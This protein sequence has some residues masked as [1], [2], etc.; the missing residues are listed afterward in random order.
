MAD[1]KDTGFFFTA[2]AFFI[3]AVVGAVTAL[4]TA[5]RS[6]EKTLQMI[7]EKTSTALDD[8]QIKGREVQNQVEAALQDAKVKAEDI[9]RQIRQ[10]AQEQ[11]EQVE[12]AAESGQK[13]L[14]EHEG[15]S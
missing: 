6:G 9:Q 15:Q 11:L 3:G 1:K 13:A 7:R 8:L 10:I 12:E 5:P 2:G 4:L 14:E